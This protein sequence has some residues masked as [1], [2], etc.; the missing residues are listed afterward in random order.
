MGM[1]TTLS[2]LLANGAS[3]FKEPKV[4]LA[5]TQSLQCVLPKDLP[6]VGNVQ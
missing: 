4:G 2:S 6:L 1:K 3:S 5:G